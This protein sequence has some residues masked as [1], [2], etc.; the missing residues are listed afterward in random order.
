MVL[1][2]TCFGFVIAVCA[3]SMVACGSEPEPVERVEAGPWEQRVGAGFY[4]AGQALLARR[5]G[6]SWLLW[7]SYP[8]PDFSSEAIFL[9]R[10]E[11]DGVRVGSSELTALNPDRLALHPDG[12][13]TAVRNHCGPNASDTCFQRDDFKGA[14][15]ETV[16]P[17][18]TRTH[19]QHQ[20][21]ANG[22]VVASS[23]VGS[24]DPNVTGLASDG[25][26][27][28]AAAWH[29]SPM[30][31]RFDAENTLL[32]SKEI[33]PRVVPPELSLDAPRDEFFR[34]AELAH[35][36]PTEPVAF[37]A[38][39]VVAATV[40]RGTLVALNAAHGLE[41]ALPAD[42]RCPDVVVASFGGLSEPARYVSVPTPECEQLPKLAVVDGHAVVATVLRIEKPPE[43]NDTSQYDIGLAI[44][45][46]TTGAVLSRSIAFGA[47]D[48]I[49]HA[50]AACGT[51]NVCLGGMTGA[52]SVDTGSTVSL[53]DG[54]VLPVT[55][56]G[57][58]GERWTLRSSRHS[59]VRLLAAAESGLLFF[60]TV[61]GAITHTADSD[62]WLG[63]NQGLFG[64]IGTENLD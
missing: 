64:L 21:D 46:L 27:F 36:F 35:Q 47:E 52:K 3:A 26:G 30:L 11:A 33:L 41:L 37:E 14:V 6:T 61:D 32:Q 19:T 31:Y 5:D 7:R 34:N 45:N 16:W 40:A 23:E 38:G 9:E 59:E 25:A 62:P 51:G 49:V 58:V 8:D 17:P 50:V 53:G 48:D 18:F 56:S 2:P 44:V 24:N 39:V 15:R 10:F 1:R 60:A 28:Y 22:D 13:L 43:P 12:S 42:P 55:L 54:F 20:L 57:E 29:G 4:V 63:Y